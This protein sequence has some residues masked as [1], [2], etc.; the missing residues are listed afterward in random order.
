MNNLLFEELP[1]LTVYDKGS[2]ELARK[3]FNE[4]KSQGVI[5]EGVFDDDIW[6]LTD[7]YARIR[8][9]FQINQVLYKKYYEEIFQLKCD[10]FVAYLKTYIVLTLGQLV[11]NSVKEIVNDVLH[12]VSCPPDILMKGVVLSLIHIYMCIRDRC[13]TVR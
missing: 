10:E 7:D 5:I 6:R 1:L 12:I 11:L 4:Y 9:Y 8:I 13:Y 2:I 3:R